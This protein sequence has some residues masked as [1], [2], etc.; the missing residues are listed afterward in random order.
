MYRTANYIVRLKHRASYA[1]KPLSVNQLGILILHVGV[2]ELSIVGNQP[3]SIDPQTLN[4]P[5]A[6]E[7]LLGQKIPGFFPTPRELP[8]RARECR[9]A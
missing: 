5:E 3:T 4:I 8:D 1:T 2:A 6:E 7:K 9:A